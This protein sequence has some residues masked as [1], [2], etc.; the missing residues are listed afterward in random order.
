VN[1][2]SF[3]LSNGVYSV[4]TTEVFV[5]TSS[6][7]NSKISVQFRSNVSVLVE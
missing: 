5:N 7:H 4:Y 1:P 6:I 3:G 2:I